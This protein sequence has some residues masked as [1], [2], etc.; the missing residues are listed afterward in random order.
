MPRKFVKGSNGSLWGIMVRTT[1]IADRLLL[2][3][4]LRMNNM[5]T[6]EEIYTTCP[7]A[8][9]GTHKWERFSDTI[10]TKGYMCEWCDK[11]VED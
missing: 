7:K 8:P 11:E 6:I 5:P 9:N 4:Y 2:E 10:M 1:F 3:E